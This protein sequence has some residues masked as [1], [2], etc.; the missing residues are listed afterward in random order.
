MPN[1]SFAIRG[2]RPLSDDEFRSH[3]ALATRL[4]NVA[5]LL[6]AGAS[7]CAGGHVM[8]EIWADMVAAARD[9][10]AWL[11]ME[12]FVATGAAEGKVLPNIEQLLD[13][14]DIADADLGRKAD[15][16]SLRILRQHRHELR[17]AIL[18]ASVL[19]ERLWKR[20]D[21][22]LDDARFSSHVRLVARMI[23]NRQPGQAAPWV[24]TTNYDLAIEWAAESLGVHCANGFSGLHNRTFRPASFDLGLR[25]VQARGEARFGAYNIFLGKL[26]GS[27]SWKVESDGSI[28]E[29]AAATQWPRLDTFLKSGEPADWPGLLIFPGAAKYFQVT[30]FVYGEIIRRFTEF[31]AKP[32]ACLIICGYGFS[33]DHINRLIISALQNPTLQIIIYLPELAEFGIFP[34]LPAPE[35][36]RKPNKLLER[37]LRQQLHQVTVRGWVSRLILTHS[38]PTFPSR[39]FWTKHRNRPAISNDFVANFPVTAPTAPNPTDTEQEPAESIDPNTKA[40][41][42]PPA[43]P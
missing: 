15:G 14:L 30:G 11:E 29:Q 27:L 7:T 21:R 1:T 16:A 34:T 19:D 39:P 3:L 35:K 23:G 4:E 28:L 12:K 2:S 40:S 22:L 18:R 25:N 43:D 33:D 20:P 9:S 26:H 6:G 32:N 17:K 41:E 10:A 31:L 36:L 24:F 37:L 13:Q 8:S 38:P 5:V 42:S